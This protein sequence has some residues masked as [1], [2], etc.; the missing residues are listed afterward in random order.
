[1]KT[2][3]R[4]IRL[5]V[6]QRRLH[7]RRDRPRRLLAHRQRFHQAP[8]SQNIFYP[9][10]KRRRPDLP[11]VQKQHPLQREQHRQ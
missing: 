5:R 4:D 2:H 3:R 10:E 11:T 7:H 9:L 1:M 6:E 8:F